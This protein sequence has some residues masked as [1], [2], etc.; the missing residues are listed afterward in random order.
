LPRWEYITSNAFFF[1]SDIITDFRAKL[2]ASVH[3]EGSG[4]SEF[5]GK[6]TDAELLNS[7]YRIAYKVYKAMSSPP[8]SY[9]QYEDVRGSIVQVLTVFAQ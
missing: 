3:V 7:A 4:T 8:V 1:F 5:N 2:Y 9:D 6:F